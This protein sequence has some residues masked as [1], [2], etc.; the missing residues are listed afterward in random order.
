V[1]EQ[2]AGADWRPQDQ[3]RLVMGFLS[4]LFGGGAQQSNAAGM[5]YA[6]LTRDQWNR[7]VQTFVPVENQLISYATDATLPG[8]EMAKAST[9]VNSSYASQEGAMQ[10]QLRGLGV[11]LTPEEQAAK[12][13]SF[14]LS[15]SLADV[16]AQNTARELTRNRQE[17]ILGNPAPVG[18]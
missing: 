3:R 18:V 7:Y 11:E 2:R 8:Q 1:V 9:R 10:R 15:K 16:Q 12:N 14:G 6:A 17:S 5:T 4:S 13:R